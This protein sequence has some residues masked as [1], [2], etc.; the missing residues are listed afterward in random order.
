MVLSIEEFISLVECVFREGN[1]YADLVQGQFDEKFPET[2][3]PHRNGA[4]RLIKKFC[5]T[6]LYEYRHS[7]I[8]L[9]TPFVSAQRLSE[10]LYMCA[11]YFGLNLIVSFFVR[12]LY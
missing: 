9:P 11:V 4:R 6:G 5:E 2:P 3:V 7:W 12:F 10:R 8:S 1:R